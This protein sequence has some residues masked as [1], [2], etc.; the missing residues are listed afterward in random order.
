M[1]ASVMIYRLLM[2]G[3]I[4]VVL[5]RP[6]S[7]VSSITC[8]ALIIT[9]PPPFVTVTP[10]HS[11]RLYL[12]FTENHAIAVF[13]ENNIIDSTKFNIISFTLKV[14]ISSNEIYINFLL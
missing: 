4:F 3:F 14:V 2:R 5:H 12:V 8:A 10:T 1:Y 13:L 7:F 9:E 6:T 11:Y